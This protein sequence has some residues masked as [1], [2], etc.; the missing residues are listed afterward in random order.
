MFSPD[1]LALWPGKCGEIEVTLRSREVGKFDALLEA[2]A[3]G[4]KRGARC[5][6]LSMRYG[7]IEMGL[8]NVDRC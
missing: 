8:E 1:F 4:R 3:L 7:G 2:G 5:G 6:S